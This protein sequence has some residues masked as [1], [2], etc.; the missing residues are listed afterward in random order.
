MCFRNRARV[1][2]C[3]SLSV[4]FQAGM[5]VQRMPFFIFQKE[6]PSGS[7][8]TP[9][10]ASCGG[11]GFSPRATGDAEASPFAVPW[12]IAV[13]RVELDAGDQICVG[14]GDRIRNPG[15]FAIEGCA[16]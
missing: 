11:T 16:Q 6:T 4:L 7:S 10:A 3:W 12:H 9:S 1:H 8:S 14:E 2:I 15:C 13:R 5:P